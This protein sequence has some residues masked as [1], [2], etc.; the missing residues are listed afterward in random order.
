MEFK[1][2][3][4]SDELAELFAWFESHKVENVIDMGHG[5]KIIDVQKCVSSIMAQIKRHPGN[6][7]YLGM[8]YKLFCIREELINQGK[9]IE[10]S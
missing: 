6:P 3:Y 2:E 8:T 4:T 5:E 7:T 10:N 9:V 1:T